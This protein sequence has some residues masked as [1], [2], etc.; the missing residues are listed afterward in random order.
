[1]V[2]SGPPV[3]EGWEHKSPR[4]SQKAILL[5]FL[6]YGPTEICYQYQHGPS[7]TNHTM[8]DAT[9]ALLST[10]AMLESFSRVVESRR[11]G[12][13]AVHRRRAPPR[14]S[15]RALLIVPSP[16][17]DTRPSLVLPSSV[18]IYRR[19]RCSSSSSISIS[20]CRTIAEPERALV[21]VERRR[22]L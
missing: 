14:P 6:H 4:P 12:G 16:C 2:E 11:R 18:L 19:R 13:G 8:R 15:G 20:H 9:R 17:T 22:R 21:R 10:R 3:Y 1:V 5:S 7:R